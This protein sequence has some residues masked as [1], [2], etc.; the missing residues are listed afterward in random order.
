MSVGRVHVRP[1][2]MRGGVGALR[3]LCGMSVER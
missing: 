1:D 3:G 2:G